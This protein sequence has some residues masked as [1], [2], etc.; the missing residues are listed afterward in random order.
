MVI[1]TSMDCTHDQYIIRAME[2]GCDVIT[3]KPVTIDAGKIN[4]IL[5]AIARTGRKLRVAFNYRYAPTASR[6]REPLIRGAIGRPL[7]VDFSWMLDTRH[8]ADY[9]RRWHAD[10]DRSGG[11]LVRCRNDVMMT[12]SLLAYCPWEGYRVAITGDRGRVELYVKHGSHIMAGPST[13]GLAAAQ[14]QRYAESLRVFPMFDVPDTVEI[15]PAEGAHG[16][17]DTLICQDF[18]LPNPSADS[19]RRA[20]SHLDGAASL[21]V[22]ISANESIHTGLPVQCDQLVQLV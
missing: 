7:V 1:V 22:G 4:G 14:S 16:G 12:Y 6:L 19:L 17:G 10:K 8:G 9:F 5:K 18:F 13:K 20:A 21:R 3:E 11:L 15:P 2:L